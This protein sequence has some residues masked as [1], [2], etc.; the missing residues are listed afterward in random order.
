VLNGGAA[1]SQISHELG[2]DAMP[3]IGA[4]IAD[5]QPDLLEYRKFSRGRGLEPGRAGNDSTMRAVELR[6][7][8]VQLPVKRRLGIAGFSYVTIGKHLRNSRPRT[9][10]AGDRVLFALQHQKRPHGSERDAALRPAIPNRGK[11]VFQHDPAELESQQH[12]PACAVIGAADQRQLALSGGDTRLREPKF[13][14]F[15][16]DELKRA[17]TGRIVAPMPGTVTR[18]LAEPGAGLQRGAPL[19]V[20]EAMKMEHTL[21]A[22][23]DGRLK[24]LKCAVGDFVQ[25]GT[26]LADFEPGAE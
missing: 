14:G 15:V 6:A 12:I 1:D 3:D 23:A 9:R 2:V 26:E 21:R 17:A 25:E 20:L 22:P 13:F 18:I 24:A 4:S 16:I 5:R 19:I 7:Y 8:G 11:L 10:A